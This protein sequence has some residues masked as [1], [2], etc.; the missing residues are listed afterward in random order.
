M[1]MYMICI[2]IMIIYMYGIVRVIIYVSYIYI[3]THIAGKWYASTHMSP[4]IYIYIYDYIAVS[5]G[6]LQVACISCLLHIYSY[7][8]TKSVCLTIVDIH[9]AWIKQYI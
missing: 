2:L 8:P 4:M 1:I 7:Y 9:V 3:Y 6:D 5:T